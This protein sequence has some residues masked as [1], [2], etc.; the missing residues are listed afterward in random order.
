[1]LNNEILIPDHITVLLRQAMDA[2]WKADSCLPRQ[3]RVFT[4]A[5][6]KTN[7]GC[8]SERLDD[9]LEDYG[10]IQ[11]KGPYGREAFDRLIDQ[12][13]ELAQVI[14]GL[15]RQQVDVVRS[16]GLLETTFEFVQQARRYDPSLDSSSIY[17]AARNVWSMNFV[18]LLLDQPVEV[19]PAVFAYSLLYPY[20]DNY[21]DDPSVPAAEK[22]EFNKRFGRRLS[23]GTVPPASDVEK[24]IF[25]LV[26]MIEGQFP[27]QSYP[28]VYGSLLAI[29]HAQE[30]S[31]SLLRKN[32]SPFEIDVLSICLEKGG[33]SVL[34]DGFLVAGHLSPE[35]QEILFHYGAFTQL[36]DDLQDVTIDKENGLM[37]V[38]S[39]TAGRWPLDGVTSRTLSFGS[40]L[41]SHLE[42]IASP[43]V[44]PL[45][46]IMSA[47][48]WPVAA[49]AAYSARGLYTDAYLASLQEAFPVRFAYL[50][51]VRSRHNLPEQGLL[52]VFAPLVLVEE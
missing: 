17:Q 36:F 24:V 45:V 41:L 44:R 15:D 39:T 16:S 31:I 32:A 23:G 33:A 48:I 1:V 40:S 49:E 9:L 50:D 20:T 52:D 46:E 43:E 6:Q 3:G 28:S 21:L 38:F 26:G 5:Q 8:L 11:K 42:E 34:A 30:R 51:E 37:T 13:G 2:W 4:T 22:A 27:R 12:A 14:Y 18:Q 47:T 10:S 25:D 29:H 35:Q 19:T 7:E